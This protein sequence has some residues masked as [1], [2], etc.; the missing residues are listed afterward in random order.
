MIELLQDDYVQSFV[1]L[2][3]QLTKNSPTATFSNESKPIIDNQ[4]LSRKHR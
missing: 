1:C 4:F 2:V 3:L